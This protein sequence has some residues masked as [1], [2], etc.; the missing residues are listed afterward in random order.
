M[1]TPPDAEGMF[2][3]SLNPKF[4]EDVTKDIMSNAAQKT[5][6]ERL[7]EKANVVLVTVRRDFLARHDLRVMPMKFKDAANEIR[8]MYRE[9]YRTWTHD[10]LIEFC[11]LKDGILAADAI[12]NDLI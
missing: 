10:E 1:K 12:K 4:I 5:E 6:E 7:I 8:L 9:Y 2:G 3:R 11:A